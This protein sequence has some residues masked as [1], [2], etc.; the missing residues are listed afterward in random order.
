V[1]SGRAR[2]GPPIRPAAARIL[3]RERTAVQAS[4]APKQRGLKV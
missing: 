3:A 1:A 4:A 2:A